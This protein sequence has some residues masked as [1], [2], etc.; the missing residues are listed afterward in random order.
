[1]GTPHCNHYLPQDRSVSV[2]SAG[3][4]PDLLPSVK[5]LLPDSHRALSP[6]SVI[7]SGSVFKINWFVYIAFAAHITIVK[8]NGKWILRRQPVLYRYNDMIC[9]RSK[10]GTDSFIIINTFRYP[11]SP[12]KEQKYRQ[13]ILPS[14]PLEGISLQGSDDCR[15]KSYSQSSYEISSSDQLLLNSPGVLKPPLQCRRRTAL[16]IPR[17]HCLLIAIICIS[18]LI[19]FCFN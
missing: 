2:S 14:F 11:S 4:L 1:M 5:Q 10:T 19:C 13:I 8:T 9:C 17:P 15:Y 16:L 7:L 18:F 12:V 3:I 6:I